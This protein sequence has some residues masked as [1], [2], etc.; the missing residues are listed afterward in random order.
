MLLQVY[1]ESSEA[2]KAIETLREA[3][4]E[5]PDKITSE[6]QFLQAFVV[7]HVHLDIVKFWKALVN[8]KVFRIKMKEIILVL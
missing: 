4:K 8:K 6:G 1:H 7:L 3:F 5:H 2:E